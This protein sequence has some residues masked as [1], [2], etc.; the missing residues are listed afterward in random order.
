MSN[1]FLFFLFFVFFA[2]GKM[3]RLSGFLTGKVF[4]AICQVESKRTRSNVERFL[5]PLPFCP[6]P[7]LIFFFFIFLS[8]YQHDN[9]LL[10]LAIS[11]VRLAPIVSIRLSWA[12]NVTSDLSKGAQ[13]PFVSCTPERWKAQQWWSSLGS[14]SHTD[15]RV[16]LETLDLSQSVVFTKYRVFCVAK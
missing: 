11:R 7:F 16:L 4:E 8:A 10:I 6:S 3:L 14:K 2:V 12:I 1:W 5:F 15:D 13:S 9:W